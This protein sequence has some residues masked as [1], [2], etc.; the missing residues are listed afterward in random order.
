MSWDLNIGVKL[1]VISAI[2]AEVI[3]SPKMDMEYFTFRCH[4]T[5]VPHWYA[6]SPTSLYQCL[7]L[8]TWMYIRNDVLVH[9]SGRFPHGDAA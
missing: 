3:A 8:L 2:S 4:G 7:R 5:D 6:F 1:N 9:G